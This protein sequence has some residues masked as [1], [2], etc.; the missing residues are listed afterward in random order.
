[1]ELVVRVHSYIQSAVGVYSRR[2]GIGAGSLG[3]KLVVGVRS[4][5]LL[6]SS[7]N[8]YSQLVVRVWHWRRWLGFRAGAWGLN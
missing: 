2:L 7:E 5:Q 3:L 1:M 4:W 6:F 8:L